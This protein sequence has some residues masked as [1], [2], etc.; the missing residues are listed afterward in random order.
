MNRKDDDNRPPTRWMHYVCPRCKEDD[1]RIISRD[2]DA[3]QKFPAHQSLSIRCEQC[4]KE[5]HEREWAKGC[6]V[7][8]RIHSGVS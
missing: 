3:T 7:P 8:P 5:D 2:P 1:V 4:T 6:I